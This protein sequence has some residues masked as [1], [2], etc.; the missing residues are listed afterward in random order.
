MFGESLC[1]CLGV[2]ACLRLTV[3]GVH[4]VC[5]ESCVCLEPLYVFLGGHYM[6][7]RVTLFGV[8]LFGGHSVCFRGSLCMCLGVHSV[9]RSSLCVCLGGLSVISASHIFMQSTS[10]SSHGAFNAPPTTGV[11][12]LQHSPTSGEDPRIPELDLLDESCPWIWEQ[13][14]SVGTKPIPVWHF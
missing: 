11:P 4:H 13:A 8:T 3:F 5:F 10:C 14:G 2:T 7:C 1:M 6:F 12:P 9:F